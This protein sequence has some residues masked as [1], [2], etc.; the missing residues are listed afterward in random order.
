[1]TK[2]TNNSKNNTIVVSIIIAICI[3]AVLIISFFIN[4]NNIISKE[5]GEKIDKLYETLKNKE[6]YTFS[7]IYD[8][9]N[10]IY[11]AKTSDKAYVDSVV[12]GKEMEMIVKDGNTYLIKD[13]EK[14]YY[15]YKNNDTNIN[16]IEDDLK[17]LDGMKYELGKEKINGKTYSYIEYSQLTNFTVMDTSNLNSNSEVKTRFYFDMND[18]VYIK[19]T[20]GNYIELLKVEIS[21]NINDNLF[22]IPS[23]Y[24]ER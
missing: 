21:D 18:L 4:T 15:I 13:D 12:D 14:A 7:A 19:T 22:E 11:F 24:K 23:E 20:V 10:K 1:M 16:K 5:E 8:D 17:E 2:K 6:Q 3:I 9:K